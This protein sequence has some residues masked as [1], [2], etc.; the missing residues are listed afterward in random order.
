MVGDPGRSIQTTAVADVPKAGFGEAAVA[1]GPV[2][3]WLGA[4]MFWCAF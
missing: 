4:A 1:C 2:V 3:V